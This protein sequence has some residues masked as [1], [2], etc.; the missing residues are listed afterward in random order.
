MVKSL[1]ELCKLFDRYEIV[2]TQMQIDKEY[3]ALSEN[4]FTV[5]RSV[6]DFAFAFSDKWSFYS[7]IVR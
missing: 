3:Y 5:I 1:T 6:V 4:I 2:D 7:G